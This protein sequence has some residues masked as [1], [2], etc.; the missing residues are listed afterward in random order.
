M[1]RNCC[2]ACRIPQGFRMGSWWLVQQLYNSLTHCRYHGYYN[3]IELH[4]FQRAFSCIILFNFPMTPWNMHDCS[5]FRDWK[6]EVQGQKVHCTRIHSQQMAQL[7]SLNQK[8]L[9]H[10]YHVLST[11]LSSLHTLFSTHLIT[12]YNV[13]MI[14]HRRGLITHWEWQSQNKNSLLFNHEAWAKMTRSC[15]MGVTPFIVVS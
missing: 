1:H 2:Q 11:G 6:T 3:Y 10:T 9:T 7:G 14:S 15:G 13:Y 12:S 5:Y 4:S 8:G